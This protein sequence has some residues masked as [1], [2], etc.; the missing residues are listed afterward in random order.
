MKVITS[1]RLL[2]GIVVFLTPEAGWSE[3]IDDAQVFEAED[4]EAILARA[5]PDEDRNHVTGTYLIDV[6]RDGDAV[7]PTRYRERIRALGPTV[8]PDLQ[9]PG[10]Y[11]I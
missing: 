4:D 6:R 2:D 7:V 9:R 5:R 10:S 8:R 3:R 1:Q 11:T